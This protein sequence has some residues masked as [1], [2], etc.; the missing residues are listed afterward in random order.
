M[1]HGRPTYDTQQGASRSRDATVRRTARLLASRHDARQLDSTRPSASTWLASLSSPPVKE[2]LVSPGE[3]L[4]YRPTVVPRSTTKLPS[5]R[6]AGS[7]NYAPRAAVPVSRS[8]A[9]PESTSQE[10][11][12]LMESYHGPRRRE[13]ASHSQRPARK[14]DT[15]DDAQ[16]SLDIDQDAI[17]GIVMPRANSTARATELPPRLI[18]ELQALAAPST[19]QVRSSN[20]SVSSVSSPSTRFSSSP[21]PW[22]LSTTTTPTSWSSASPSIVPQV[23]MTDTGKRSPI[24]PLR[25]GKRDKIPQMPILPKS[26]PHVDSEWLASTKE[27]SESSSK[28]R[29]PL[30]TPAPTPPPRTSSAKHSVSRSTSKSD[31][32]RVTRA[33]EPTPSPSDLERSPPAK[34]VRSGNGATSESMQHGTLTRAHQNLQQSLAHTPSRTNR[35]GAEAQINYQI[36]NDRASLAIRAPESRPIDDSP[37][38]HTEVVQRQERQMPAANNPT[39]PGDTEAK[40]QSSPSHTEKKSRLGIFGRRNKSPATEPQKSPRKLQRKGPTAGTGHEGYGRYAKRGRKTSEEST[41]AKGSDSERSV[42]STRRHPLFSSRSKSGRSNNRHDRNSQSDLDEFAASRM[43]PIPIV[44]GSGNSMRSDS[45]GQI[46]VQ[47]T[48]ATPGLVS[49]I[50]S[51]SQRSLGPYPFNEAQVTARDPAPN[52]R[53]GPTLAIRRSQRFG[54]DVETFNLPMPIRTEGLSANLY[55]N[56]QDESRSSVFPTST[57]STNT[58]LNRSDTALQRPKEKKSKMLRWNIFRRKGVAAEPER[59]IRLPTS[60]PEELAV[61]VSAIPVTRSMPYYAM[62]DSESDVNPPEHMGDYLAQVVDSSA[63]SPLTTDY[64][65]DYRDPQPAQ[66]QYEDH[67]FLPAAPLSPPQSYARSPPAVPLRTE[68]VPLQPLQTSWRPPRLV[69]VGRIPPIVPR[70]ERQHK[71]SRVS[72]SQ[73]FVSSGAVENPDTVSST[74]ETT[75]SSHIGTD[76]LPSRNFIPS[77]SAVPASAP[78]PRDSESSQWPSRQASSLSTSSDSGGALSLLGPALVPGLAGG[79]TSGRG[80]SPSD[81]Y[82]PGSPTVDDIWNEYDDFIDQ[83]MSPSLARKSIKTLAYATDSSL[84]RPEIPTQLLGSDRYPMP[85]PSDPIL[86]KFPMPG[87]KRPVFADAPVTSTTSPIVFARPSLRERTVGEDIRLR[88]SRIVSALNSPTGSVSPFSIRDLLGEYENYPRNSAKLSEHLSTSS[89]IQSPERLTTTTSAPEIAPETS[90]Q[91]HVDMLE[92]VER[93]KNPAAQSELH[94]ASLMVAKWL[95]FG[96]VLF[97]PVHDEIQTITE[98]HVL[99]I[100]GLGNEDWSIYCAVS[101]EAQ[102]AFIH[103]LKEKTTTR[104]PKISKPSQHAPENHRRSEVASFHDR[105]PFPPSFFAA[106][107][108]RFPPAM[109][110]AKMKNIVSE[111]RRVLAPG[112]YLELMLLDLDIVNMGVQTRRAVRELKFRMTTADKQISLRPIIDNVQSV[113]GARGFRNISR[114]VV[115]VPVA[116][117][118]SGSVDSSSSSRSS[119]GSDPLANRESGEPRSGGASPRMTFGHIGRGTN[120]SLNDLLSDRSDNADLRIGRIVSKTARTWWQHCF[121]ASVIGNGNLGRSIFADKNVLGECKARGSSFKMLIAYAQ[122][123]VFGARRRTMSEPVVPTLATAGGKRQPLPTSSNNPHTA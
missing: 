83:V 39:T 66:E 28:K 65:E 76:V 35:Y 15:S 106:V 38:Q 23:S 79:S 89:A 54:P 36:G 11:P 6:S 75:P 91:E 46:D 48:P 74:T 81:G 26:F 27:S 59:P 93:G 97:S 109:A 68:P 71:P 120:L 12:L 2:G 9:R 67:V 60:P 37:P 102:R 110:E 101:F 115:G 94:Y 52:Q 103:D 100:D 85:Q 34:H 116:G 7:S 17:F 43:K 51:Q 80:T 95:S 90:H 13:Q 73:P 29:T 62:M 84:E 10:V 82:L 20:K 96:R 53:I 119:R 58:D 31:A 77:D 72:F 18:P 64:K 50:A 112:G 16:T 5:Q 4:G 107:V 122:K 105:F 114:C 42:S 57:P 30:S 22:S 121:E 19:R 40:T 78:T 61:S 32:R 63:V 24:I 45:G 8:V 104:A 49:E 88:R 99:V 69:R 70:I 117:R 41:S 56:S 87:M 25:A 44:G 1:S 21:S 118:P 92:V 98:R 14:N 108:L 113:L 123:P 55:I 33:Q 3:N 47:S 111:C 86:S